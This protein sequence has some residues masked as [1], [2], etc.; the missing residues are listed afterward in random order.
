MEAA[1]TDTAARDTRGLQKRADM[2]PCFTAHTQSF[3]LLEK[4]L[5]VN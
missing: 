1:F 2:P 4:I 5:F 3:T